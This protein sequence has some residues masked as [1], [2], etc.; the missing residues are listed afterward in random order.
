MRI[1]V[2]VVESLFLVG[3]FV[4]N[5]VGCKMKKI[6][7]FLMDD[8][9]TAIRIRDVRYYNNEKPYT[10]TEGHDE[11]IDQTA[12]GFFL[13]FLCGVGV[14]FVVILYCSTIPLGQ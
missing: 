11:P 10:L 12:L 2:W 1:S 6:K 8:F 5:V 3:E 13:G 9:V 4:V 7:C 14:G